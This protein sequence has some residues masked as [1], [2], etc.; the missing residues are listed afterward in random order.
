MANGIIEGIVDAARSGGLGQISAGP[1]EALVD[2]ENAVAFRV[3]LIDTPTREEILGI[4]LPPNADVRALRVKVGANPAHSGYAVGLGRAQVF[5]EPGANNKVRVVLDFD[6]PLTVSRVRWVG[7]AGITVERVTPWNGAKFTGIV[8]S[9]AASADMLLTSQVRTERLELRVVR[10]ATAGSVTGAGDFA[11][12]FRIY[13][14]DG[15]ADL[16]LSIDAAAPAWRWPGPVQPTAASAQGTDDFNANGEI[17]AD[18]TDA[19]A[20]L[21]G[22]PDGAEANQTFELKLTSSHAALLSLTA[23]SGAANRDVGR[24]RRVLYD[25]A[26]EVELT[27][28]AEGQLPLALPL[29]AAPAGTTPTVRQIAMTVVGEAPKLRVR[30]AIGP[31]LSEDVV[32]VLDAERAAIARPRSTRGIEFLTGVRLPLAAGR[33]GAEA[34]IVLWQHDP[35]LDRPSEPMEMAATGPVV[36]PAG[37]TAAWVTFSFPRAV[38]LD[39]AEPPWIALLVSRGTALWSLAADTTVAAELLRGPPAG[40]WLNLPPPFDVGGPFAGVGAALRLMGSGAEISLL[41]IRVPG[42]SKSA[43]VSPTAKGLRVELSPG[44]PLGAL[45]VICHHAAT[46]SVRDVIATIDV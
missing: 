7:T 15:P 24:V 29:P 20:A 6:A 31:P 42:T 1:I 5:D 36:L 37:D 21:T 41:S 2:E 9:G 19:F 13:Y 34:R 12:G 23:L 8:S 38:S 17:I 26:A 27:F 32:L 44:V 46:I 25:Q 33:D 35:T 11:A 40:P 4:A 18:L 16:E 28:D 10:G 45:D 14:A 3:R 39:A 43:D 22:D 30:P